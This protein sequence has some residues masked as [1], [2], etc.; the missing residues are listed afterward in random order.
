MH[1]ERGRLLFRVAAKK[2]PLWIRVTA[3]TLLVIA[4]GYQ[5]FRR[6]W[7]WYDMIFFTGFFVLYFF[8]F[9]QGVAVYEKGIHFPQD[10]SGARARFVAWSQIDRFYWDGDVLTIVPSASILGGG[11][12]FGTP[13][14]G[15]ALRIPPSRHTEVEKLLSAS[16]EHLS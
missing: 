10:Q 9:F 16:V 1:S 13:V 11:G 5:F 4:F 14:L 8:R 3:A 2:E 12:S 15:G 7:D 6:H